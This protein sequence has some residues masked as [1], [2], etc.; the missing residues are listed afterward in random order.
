MNITT[1][2]VNSYINL[3]INRCYKD[4]IP[5]NVPEEIHDL[6]PSYKRIAM[7][8][9][10]NDLYLTELGYSAPKSK[11][12]G[13]FKRIELRQRGVLREEYSKNNLFD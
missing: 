4:G 11:Y 8:L 6:C 7:C 2:T 1:K 3:W 13:I 10:K 12:Y 9:L 5:D